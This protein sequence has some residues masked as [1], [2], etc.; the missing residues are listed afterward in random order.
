[1]TA[2]VGLLLWS[3]THADLPQFRGKAMAGRLACFPIAALLVPAGW[4]LARRRRRRPLA[5]PYAA[6][7][8]VTL[9]FVIDLFGNAT[10][11]Y[12]EV[13]YF[14]D[15]VHA[16]NP[17][18]FVAAI[19]VLLDRTRVPRWA[20]WIMAFGL[21]CADHIT[22]EIIEYLLLE[23]VGAVEL[24]LSLVDTL[25]DQAWGLLGASVGATLALQLPPRAPEIPVTPP[26]TAAAAVGSG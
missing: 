22:W 20:T 8:L 4:W 18:L 25:S 9:P 21:G 5:F 23:G 3:A 24:D 14:D 7:V 13:E 19:A 26:P 1:M 6:A 12:V 17:V 10:R 15:A 16:I 11:L 2:L